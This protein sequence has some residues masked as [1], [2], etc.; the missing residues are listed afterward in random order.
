MTL[1]VSLARIILSRCP[2][3]LFES[4]TM[5]VKVIMVRGSVE[6]NEDQGPWYDAGAVRGALAQIL[7]Q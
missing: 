3:R 6:G 7:T 1:A 5:G 4:Q 2:L